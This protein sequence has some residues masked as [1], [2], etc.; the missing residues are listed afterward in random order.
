[1]SNMRRLLANKKRP[2]Q[3]RVAWRKR[4][5]SKAIVIRIELSRFYFNSRFLIPA[6]MRTQKTLKKTEE[7]KGSNGTSI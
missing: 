4:W 2:G 3:S 6:A 7:T 5:A 1:M